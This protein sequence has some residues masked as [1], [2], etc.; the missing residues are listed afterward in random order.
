VY[1]SIRQLS[2]VLCNTH[3]YVYIRIHHTHKTICIYTDTHMYIYRYTMY[4]YIY[5]YTIHVKLTFE[6]VYQMRRERLA[7]VRVLFLSHTHSLFHTHSLCLFLSRSF[8]PSLSLSIDRFL[9]P[10]HSLYRPLLTGHFTQI[11]PVV[12]CSFAKH[13]LHTEGDAEEKEGEGGWEGADDARDCERGGDAKTIEVEKMRGWVK[14]GEE[15]GKDGDENN[16]RDGMWEENGEVVQ[17]VD[18]EKVIM[19]QEKG[20]EGDICKD[21]TVEKQCSR[22]GLHGGEGDTV[23]DERRA[24]EMER[25]MS[26]SPVAMIDVSSLCDIAVTHVAETDVAKIS[27][28]DVAVVDVA[29][30][31][32]AKGSPSDVAVA[33]ND[34]S[35]L[36]DIA[37]T[38]VAKT[39][40]AE[41]SRFKVAM[42]DV[43]EFDVAESI[44][45]DIAAPDV[46]ETVSPPI[47]VAHTSVCVTIWGET[48]AKEKAEEEEEL[49][50]AKTHTRQGEFPKEEGEGGKK[51]RGEDNEVAEDEANTQVKHV[52]KDD[53]VDGMEG[54]G[55]G[56]S[57]LVLKETEARKIRAPVSKALSHDCDVDAGSRVEVECHKSVALGTTAAAT[58]AGGDDG[59]ADSNSS[60]TQWELATKLLEQLRET[61][62]SSHLPSPSPHVSTLSHPL[63]SDAPQAQQPSS[64]E[65]NMAIHLLGLFQN[66]L[67]SEPGFCVCV[68]ARCLC[69]CLFVSLSLSVSF[70]VSVLMSPS[71]FVSVFVCASVLYV[72]V[73][74][75]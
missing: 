12:D 6:E 1:P 28:S 59:S 67:P 11:S 25:D 66:S 19:E 34:V 24:C 37:G 30:Y 74:Y 45:S 70:S 48:R 43:S 4:M 63:R 31:D 29:E 62:L 46:V 14:K 47:D 21:V 49:E 26:L 42:T 69:L 38:H 54:G 27:H 55:E 39:D 72:Y 52:V 7:H 64:G 20:E 41:N 36:S 60:G 9:S 13:D 53:R 50:E 51:E 22:L 15:G 40:V 58:S 44:P 23:E 5:G 8:S 3:V 17:V 65:M 68:W 16:G 56:I 2:V 71:M 32:V 10:S 18:V 75:R 35:S 61:P 33:V 57:L 73:L